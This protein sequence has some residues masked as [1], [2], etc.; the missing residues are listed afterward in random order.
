[1]AEK[2]LAISRL[3]R[4]AASVAAVSSA[5]AAARRAGACAGEDCASSRRAMAHMD[6]S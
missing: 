6:R 5:A 4:E 3:W 1:M 2:I